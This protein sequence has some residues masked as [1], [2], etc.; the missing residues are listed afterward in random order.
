MSRRKL[1]GATAALI[2]GPLAAV[3]IK[4]EREIKKSGLT[5]KQWVA[6]RDKREK[7][8]R[9]K[10]DKAYRKACCLLYTSPSPR[11]S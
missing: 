2:G 8:T 11:D 6:R 1:L 7:A 10:A 5:R 3:K 9:T 4:R